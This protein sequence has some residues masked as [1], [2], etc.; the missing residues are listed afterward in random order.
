[1]NKD[2]VLEKRD[3]YLSWTVI[4]VFSV[5]RC[6][7]S[8]PN[9][10][11]NMNSYMSMNLIGNILCF[12]LWISLIIVQV[13]FNNISVKSLENPFRWF[14]WCRKILVFFILSSISNQLASAT[15]CRPIEILF[16]FR[17]ISMIMIQLLGFFFCLFYSFFLGVKFAS[18]RPSHRLWSSSKWCLAK[19]SPLF[20]KNIKYRLNN[21]YFH[22]FV[23]V[24]KTN[25]ISFNLD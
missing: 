17:H 21:N 1:M 15:A 14:C 2:R 23:F 12:V 6:S 19:H 25:R 5:E 13:L 11:H 3:V 8:L 9:S 22:S 24:Q 4:F 10:V 20:S 18:I 7:L 16:D